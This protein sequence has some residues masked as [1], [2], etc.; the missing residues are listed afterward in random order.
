M[1]S[2]QRIKE[3]EKEVDTL[4]AQIGQELASLDMAENPTYYQ[5][6]KNEFFFLKAESLFLKNKYRPHS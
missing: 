3:L 1:R 2:I 6:L 5:Q 4:L